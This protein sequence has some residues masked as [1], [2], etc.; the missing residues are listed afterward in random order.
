MKRAK[1]GKFQANLSNMKAGLTNLTSGNV[2]W[3]TEHLSRT[4]WVMS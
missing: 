3:R 4:D 2:D 1:V